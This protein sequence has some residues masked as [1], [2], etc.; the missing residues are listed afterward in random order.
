MN[1][2]L[3]MH[4]IIT[5]CEYSNKTKY[6]L[7]LGLCV[8]LSA[9]S[10]PESTQQTQTNTAT[11][12]KS[13][14]I[15]LI[16]QD[17]IPVQIGTATSKI[18][19]SGT[20]RAINQS[21]IQTQVSAT[22][23]QVNA[24][25]GQK[26]DKGQI[27]VRLNNQDNEARLAQSRA[28][29]ISTQAQ[30]NQA[31]LM[32]Q[33]K[34]RLYDQGFIS[35]VEYEQSQ[36]DY[37]AQLENVKAQ[38]ANVD[39]AYKANQDGMIQ[40]PISGVITKRDIEPGQ[41]VSVGQTL[42]EIVDPNH[43]EIQAKLPIEQQAVLKVGYP[44][45][46]KIQGNSQDYTATL[47]RI[48]PIADQTNRQI[49][50]Y[51]QPEQSIPSLSIGAFI[52]GYIINNQNISGFQIP[53]NSIQDLKNQPYVW[54]IRNQKV[55]VQI[56]SQQATTNLAIVQNLQNGDLISRIKFTTQDINKTAVITQPQ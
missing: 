33:R 34:K 39:I 56:L 1:K 51:A 12:S 16:Q 32:V 28:N 22:A 20:I 2:D 11:Q 40:S 21:S 53:L 41:T 29:L 37:K 43:L 38:Q 46:Y 10:K 52:E 7:L 5:H 9:C 17:L 35:R 47:S 42:F 6:L 23:T 54:L 45:E 3:G 8:I 13:S 36:V 44:I 4:K 25:V 30:A 55:P 14:Q 31:Q 48:S 50:F 24:Q 27:L 26:V 18:P 15:E 49:D 19:F